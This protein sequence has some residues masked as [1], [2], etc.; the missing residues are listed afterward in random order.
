MNISRSTSFIVQGSWVQRVEV[1]GGERS[2]FAASCLLG[3]RLA[4]I[5]LALGFEAFEEVKLQSG[6]DGIKVPVTKEGVRIS[7][8]I[9]LFGATGVAGISSC[10]WTILDSFPSSP[11]PS[12][13]TG[14]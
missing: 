7:V 12:S 9:A 14:G 6:V 2:G 5:I 8:F 4:E 3:G 10:H 13:R 1:H 11:L